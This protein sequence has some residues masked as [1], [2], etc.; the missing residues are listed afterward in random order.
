MGQAKNRKEEIDALKLKGDTYNGYIN[1]SADRVR[2]NGE[3]FTPPKLVREI[4]DHLPKHSFTDKTKKFLDPACGDGAFLI[5]VVARKLDNGS[6]P[7]EALNTTYGIDLMRDN[8]VAT[9]NRL[10]TYVMSRTVVIDARV[11]ATVVRDGTILGKI[12]SL[13]E[14]GIEPEIIIGPYTTESFRDYLLMLVSNRICQGNSI[15]EDVN[16]IFN[17]Q[18][19]KE[20]A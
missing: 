12:T 17:R 19:R 4:L 18:G 13:R 10:V 8:V 6:N 15:T 7:I 9:R 5:E 11:R 3:V 14:S 2:K 16:T 1:R 20:Y